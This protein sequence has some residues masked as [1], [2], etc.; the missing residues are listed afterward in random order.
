MKG[1]VLEHKPIISVLDVGVELG[2]S[3]RLDL[4]SQTSQLELH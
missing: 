1:G 4:A 3:Q 2:G